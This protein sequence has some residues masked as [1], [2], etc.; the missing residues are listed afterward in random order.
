MNATEVRTIYGPVK[1]VIEND[2]MVWKGIPYAKT[3]VGKFRFR[4][5]EAP[6]AWEDTI[7]CDTFSPQC[8]Q[9]K[10]P[11][12][13]APVSDN[14]DCLY[15]NI[16]SS[17]TE[18]KKPVYFWINGGNFISGSGAESTYDGCVFAK[19]D[20]VVV[21][22]NYRT[23]L[24]GGFYD[25]S[26]YKALDGK[27]DENCGI[28]D[29]LLAL[30]WVKKNIEYFGGDP[31]QITVGGESAGAQI[32]AA[33]MTMPCANSLFTKAIIESYPATG[34]EEKTR[35]HFAA[36]LIDALGFDETNCDQIMN[37]TSEV[38]IEAINKMSGSNPLFAGSNLI[39]GGQDFPL[40]PEQAAAE[41]K[42]TAMPLIIGTN[43]GEGNVFFNPQ[44]PWDDGTKAFFNRWT[45]TEGDPDE[46]E[47]F[48]AYPD[49]PSFTAIRQIL[50]DKVFTG[51][52]MA[53]ANSV[54]KEAPVYVYRF[55]YDTP[56]TRQMFMGAFHSFE[57]A[58]AF[59]NITENPM[60]M[61][62]E[63]EAAS[64]SREMNGAWATFIKTGSAGWDA[65]SETDPKVHY[66]AR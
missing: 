52:S 55:D 64:V 43:K 42:I 27:W 14:E 21:T 56:A 26:E 44:M 1:G 65:Y 61:G 57:M 35:K 2:I 16:W 15:L 11:F 4:K 47:E 7:V 24:F 29:V 53:I 59:G 25:L 31:D 38:I 66:F 34:M 60:L 37:K 9:P 18:E 22:F 39:Y 63:E 6:D 62:V 13:E 50:T 5:T 23:G 10:L 8:P 40:M 51:P 32:V 58:F 17:G 12:G 30:D 48:T 28:S 41:G 3:P 45:R 54:S 36:A 20:I 19:Q 33:L 49:Y 46:N